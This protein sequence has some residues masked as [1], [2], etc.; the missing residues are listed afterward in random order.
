MVLLTG[1]NRRALVANFVLAVL[2]IEEIDYVLKCC[3]G[4]VRQGLF[5]QECLVGRNDDVGHGNQPRENIV[6]NDVVRVIVE[7]YVR[8]LFIYI[9]AGRADLALFDAFDQDNNEE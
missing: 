8:F 7:E 5:G 3:V 1:R 2:L 6:I 4:N 9:E